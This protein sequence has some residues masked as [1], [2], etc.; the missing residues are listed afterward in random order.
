MAKKHS[1]S[2]T[3]TSPANNE[4]SRKHACQT[5]ISTH[6]ARTP[7]GKTT[8]QGRDHQPPSIQHSRAMPPPLQ[9]VREQPENFTLGCRGYL[10]S[11]RVGSVALLENPEWVEYYRNDSPEEGGEVC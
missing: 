1:S 11:T 4:K 7:E 8:R 3:G 6:P 10:S 5:S 2:Q 9:A